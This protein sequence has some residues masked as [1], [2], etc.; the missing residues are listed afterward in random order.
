MTTYPKYFLG[1]T[2]E[3]AERV[4]AEFVTILN[5]IAENYAVYTGMDKGDL[6]SEGLF[7]LAE[8]VKKFDKD[9][10]DNF[11]GFAI[12]KIKDRINNY[13]RLHKNKIAVPKHIH[14]AIMLFNRIANI[15]ENIGIA[16]SYANIVIDKSYY[17][18]IELSDEDVSKIEYCIDK[19]KNIADRANTTF[20]KLIDRISTIPQMDLNVDI[21]TVEHKNYVHDIEHILSLLDENEAVVAQY[22]AKGNTQTEIAAFMNRSPAWVSNKVNSMKEKIIKEF[23]FCKNI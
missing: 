14:Q 3:D 23:N 9:R 11:S 7:G 6:F 2:V 10:S 1:E 22:L 12:F 18:Y 21:E 16:D 5:K 8:A 15:L 4:H 17:N 19:L 13:V 20:D